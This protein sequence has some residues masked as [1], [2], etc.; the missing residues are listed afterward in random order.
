VIKQDSVEL[1][2]RLAWALGVGFPE[3]SSWDRAAYRETELAVRRLKK[4]ADNA[5]AIRTSAGEIA[6]AVADLAELNDPL[7]D[8]TVELLVAL[9]PH[10]QRSGVIGGREVFLIGGL[11]DFGW[12]LHDPNERIAEHVIA[13]ADLGLF[14]LPG[15]RRARPAPPDELDDDPNSRIVRPNLVELVPISTYLAPELKSLG[16]EDTPPPQPASH[17]APPTLRE[18]FLSDWER[19]LGTIVERIMVELANAGYIDFSA[20]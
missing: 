20:G 7:R 2:A 1:D 14:D 6:S 5:E 4:R 13:A 3:Q 9:V 11:H 17:N 12:P 10:I 16:G 15:Q 19:T 18:L 8:E